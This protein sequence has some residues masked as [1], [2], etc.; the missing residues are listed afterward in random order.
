MKT[1]NIYPIP[2]FKD[3]YIWAITLSNKKTIIVDPGAAEPVETYLQENGLTL[4]AIF[5]THH[6]W[7]HTDGVSALQE[8]YQVPVYGPVNEKIASITNPLKE[9][10]KIN[11]AGFP[12]FRVIEIPG[13]TLD[14]I[15]YYAPGMLFCGDTLFAAGCGRLFEGTADEMYQSLQKLAALPDDT[16]VYCAHEYTQSNLRF[17]NAAEPNNGTIL[18][19]MKRVKEL[20]EKQLPTLPSILSEEKLTNPFLRSDSIELVENVERHEGNKLNNAVE[21]FAATRK[22][23]DKF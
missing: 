6:H 10:D 18:E 4:T 1:I 7:D 21:I 19:K 16:R 14:H 17:A 20:R 2:A 13:H 15:A 22:W 9:N 8:K 5:I 23:K 3:N 11:L 12:S